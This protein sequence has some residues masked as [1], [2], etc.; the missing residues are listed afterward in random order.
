MGIAGTPFL[1]FATDTVAS[2]LPRPMHVQSFT[3]P[4]AGHQR[5]KRKGES[6]KQEGTTEGNKEKK[7]GKTNELETE[8][9][10]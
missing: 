10:N 4:K 8:K 2:A 7:E 3:N 6:S 5:R 9:R 1:T